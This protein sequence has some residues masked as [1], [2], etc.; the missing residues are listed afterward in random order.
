MIFAL[1]IVKSYF[2]L[3]A[4]TAHESS[5]ARNTTAVKESRTPLRISNTHTHTHTHQTIQP[6]ELTKVKANPD[7]LVFVYVHHERVKSK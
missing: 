4:P 7:I 1:H 3:A 2:F 5:W 6:K